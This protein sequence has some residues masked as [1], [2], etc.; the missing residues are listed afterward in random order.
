VVAAVV[1]AAAVEA[2]STEVVAHTAVEAFTVVDHTV[3]EAIAVVKEA[4]VAAKAAIAAAKEPLAA[5]RAAQAEA[6][7]RAAA[8]KPDAA[9][10]QQK[11]AL[12][13]F[14]PPS[15]MANG[16][17]SEAAP[18]QDVLVPEP[19]Q[20]VAAHRVSRQTQMSWLTTPEIPKEHGIPSAGR[21]ARL[22]SPDRGAESG[23]LIAVMAG[24]AEAG[25]AVGEATA[26]AGEV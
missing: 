22:V 7:T 16:I 26:G 8:P 17:L 23:S 3:V 25:V 19:R 10:A 21:E 12:Q 6:D 18:E 11:A 14:V 1:T 15:M 2:A 24:A 20:L 9:Q 5:S 13:I 4:I